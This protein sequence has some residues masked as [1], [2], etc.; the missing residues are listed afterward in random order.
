M[1]K[2]ELVLNS[3]GPLVK[4]SK[5][6][7]ISWIREQFL[8]FVFSV[9]SYEGNFILL[10]FLSNLMQLSALFLNLSHVSKLH[11]LLTLIY[12]DNQYYL[13]DW[14]D[15]YHPLSEWSAQK[16]WWLHME[17]ALTENGEGREK[18]KKKIRTRQSDTSI[19]ER[20]LQYIY[21]QWGHPWPSFA[22]RNW[23][24]KLVLEIIVRF[25]DEL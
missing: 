12:L 6:R 23:Y 13:E 3:T 9:E 16:I 7:K 21:F 18:K 17:Y 4:N 20:K 25:T 11:L 10:F 14:W 1:E 15:N 24:F 2:N 8:N 5:L 22:I 19:S